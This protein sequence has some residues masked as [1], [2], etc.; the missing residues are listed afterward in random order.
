MSTSYNYKALV[1]PIITAT[2]EALE[3]IA[4]V[5]TAVTAKT[6]TVTGANL[7]AYMVIAL[8]GTDAALF[9]QT[10][11][12]DW[13]AKTGGTINICYNPIVAG[14]HAVT[15]TITSGEV[16]KMI[17]ITATATASLVPTIAVTPSNLDFS[18]VKFGVS[19]PQ[20]LTVIAISCKWKCSNEEGSS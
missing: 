7:G 9:T 15:L 12:T 10:T 6:I 2:P 13:D 14:T 4:T 16:T 17:T 3:F 20:I 5:G 11:A 1:V 8:T 18:M 19:D